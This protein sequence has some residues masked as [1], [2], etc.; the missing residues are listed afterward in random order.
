MFFGKGHLIQKFDTCRTAF[1]C[2]DIQEKLVKR[3]PNFNDAVRVSNIMSRFHDILT[4]K[5]CTFVATEQFPEGVSHMVKSIQLPDKTPVIPKLQ[6]SMLTPEMLPYILG[7]EAMGL[8]PVQQAVL[9]GHETH[10]C[11]INTADDLLSRGIRVAVVVD[12]CGAQN[13]LDHEVAL[14]DMAKWEGLTL[15]TTIG[16][17]MQLSRGDARIMKDVMKLSRGGERTGAGDGNP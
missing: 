13:T 12:G 17:I 2:C 16:L 8:A 6:P 14:M 3:I 15:T 10:V 11:I 7:D 9:W 4:P 1:M 5:F